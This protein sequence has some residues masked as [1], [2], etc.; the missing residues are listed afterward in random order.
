APA[1]SDPPPLPP[2]GLLLTLVVPGGAA[3]AAKLRAGDV[4]LS[5]NGVQLQTLNDLQTVAAGKDIPAQ[6][7][8]DGAV[9]DVK[10]PPGKLG[11]VPSP[12]PAPTALRKQGEAVALVASTRAEPSR[13]LP[14]SRVEVRHIAGLFPAQGSVTLLG[15]DASEQRLDELAAQPGG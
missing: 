7:W 9:L 8:R 10:L 11:V 1:R 15:S 14:A 12:E 3:Q 5:Y 4:L 2:H 6:L 13:P